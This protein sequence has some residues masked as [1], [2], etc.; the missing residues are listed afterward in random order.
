MAKKIIYRAGL[1]PYVVEDGVIEMLFMKPSKE[2][3]G[4]DTFQLCK[5][6]LEPGETP[7]QA[8]VR[9]AQEELGFF[10]GNVDSEIHKL[11]V[12]MGRTTVFFV[13]VKD[14]TMFGDPHF[15]TKE[16]KWMTPEQ[17][18]STGRGL[19]RPVIKAAVR[20]IKRV[21]GLS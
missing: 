19:H 2:K 5:G 20:A 4:G 10:T 11:G 17:F 13:R 12:F 7:E 8:A 21:E 9:E 14:K 1:I 18:N 3:F 6:K 16:T 15:E